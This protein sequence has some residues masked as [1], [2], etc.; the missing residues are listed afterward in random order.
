MK[1]LRILLIEDD[2][3]ICMMLTELLAMLGHE[4]CGTAGTEVEAIAAAA[5]HAPDLMIV[6]ANL[7][8]GSGVS[9]MNA[10]LR[11]TAMPHI[12]MTGGSRLGIPTNAILLQKPFATAGLKAALD[13]AASQI[14]AAPPCN[15]PITM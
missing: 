10:I 13:K 3:V 15:A 1:R 11:L 4:V 8:M 5:R 12:F 14:A 9:A 6:D 2:A 7:Q